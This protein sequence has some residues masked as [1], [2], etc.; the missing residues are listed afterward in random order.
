VGKVGT[1]LQAEAMAVVICTITTVTT[2][3][4]F[5]AFKKLDILTPEL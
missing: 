5:T 3:N 4:S 2:E 1:M